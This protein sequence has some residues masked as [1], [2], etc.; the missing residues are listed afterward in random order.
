MKSSSSQSRYVKVYKEGNHIGR[1]VNLFAFNN[2]ESLVAALSH[3]FDTTI[4]LDGDGN[5]SVSRNHHTLK[6]LDK[7]GYW[8]VAGDISWNN[9]LSRAQRLSINSPRNP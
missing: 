8:M 2:Y 4:R 7:D 5:S 1:K 3:M 6:Y 9:F